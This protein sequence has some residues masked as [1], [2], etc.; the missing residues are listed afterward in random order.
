MLQI[1][2]SFTWR[3]GLFSLKTFVAAMIALYIAFRL[4]LTQPV[5][6]V[7]TVY[8]VSQP[9]A[10]MVLAKSIYRVIGTVVG[11]VVSVALVALFSSSRELFLIALALWFGIGTFVAIYLR[12]APQAYAAVLAGYSAAIIGLPAVLAPETAFD[13]AV[14]RCLEIMLG[15]A[16]STIMHSVVFPESAG[17]VLRKALNATLPNMAQWANDALG[18]HESEAKGLLDRGKIINSVVSLE[19]MRIFA[20]LDTPAI[21]N[22]DA[23]IRQFQGKLFSLLALLVAVYDRMALLRAARPDIAASLAP[24]LERSAAHITE[25]A[26]AITLDDSKQEAESERAL[27]ADIEEMLPR[28][29]DLRASSEAFLVRIILLRLQDLLATWREA[30]WL[31]THIKAGSPSPASVP[32]PTLRPYRDITFALIGA[33][34]STFTVLLT[35][36]FWILTAWDHGTSAVV[37]AGIMCSLMA[38][39][40]NPV[41]AITGFLKMSGIAVAVAAIYVFV[42]L[43]GLTTFPA[44]VVALAP[45]LLFCGLLLSVPAAVLFTMPIVLVGI[46]QIGLS[47]ANVPYD[48]VTFVDS[49]IGIAVGIAF[50]AIAITILRPLGSEWTV[51]RLKRGILLDLS[52]ISSSRD[53]PNP[54]V[55]QNRMFDRINALLT[56][57]DPMEPH[58]R[59]TMQGG[60]ASLRVGLNILTM[61]RSV[62]LLPPHAA[63]QMQVVLPALAQHFDRAARGKT[64]R[65]PIQPLRLARNVVLPHED[66]AYQ[67][68]AAESLYSIE[69]TLT[70]HAG[71]FGL[72]PDVVV[73]VPDAEPVPA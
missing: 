33:A 31:R 38:P 53:I 43:P 55:F 49:Y 41:I 25:S 2:R 22:V 37:F 52:H 58:Q 48:F 6:C 69:T 13:I 34:I 12:D 63:R 17:N 5:W 4:N 30:V 21:R 18:G 60:L 67:I 27:V 9:L 47:N 50:S 64:T 28:L 29:T 61:R 24:L 62:R 23:V 44:L 68:R 35:S 72:E 1:I 32:A 10:G 54:I 65:S 15:I 20:G 8:I 7:G 19:S 40:D 57:L 3:G 71:F 36:L 66:N 39:Q 11:A 26:T 45:F 70:Q 46:P 14:S 16:C 73:V 59:R 56:R 42:I 51:K